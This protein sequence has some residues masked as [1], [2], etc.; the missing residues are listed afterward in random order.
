MPAKGGGN[1][2]KLAEIWGT[3]LSCDEMAWRSGYNC[4]LTVRATAARMRQK[5]DARFQV[6]GNSRPPKLDPSTEKGAWAIAE[7]IRAYWAA[8]GYVVTIDV[9]PERFSPVIRGRRWEVVTDLINGLPRGYR[10]RRAA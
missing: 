10:H 4:G 2:D 5:G 9:R 7:G 8:Q 6:R 3:G 1:I